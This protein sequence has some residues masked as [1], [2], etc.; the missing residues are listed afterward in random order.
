MTTATLYDTD[1]YAW[2][3]TQADLLRQEQFGKL[4]LTNLIEEIE[5][6]GKNRQREVSHRLQVLIA[7]LLKWHFQPERRSPSWE[8]TIRNQRDELTD[9]LADNPSLR[10]QVAD[11]I[12]RSYP[13]ARRGV[14]QGWISKPSLSL[15]R[16][17]PNRSST[18]VSS[19][20][21]KRLLR[22]PEASPCCTNGGCKR[23]YSQLA[24]RSATTN[25]GRLVLARGMTGMIEASPT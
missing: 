24:I 3:Q 7:H 6:M 1:F 14:Q 15:V 5:D 23:P 22:R 2:T 4:D 25:A 20:R 17:Q 11:Y 16:T 13:R 12:T 8:T 18:R 19:H 21:N 9:L 10:S